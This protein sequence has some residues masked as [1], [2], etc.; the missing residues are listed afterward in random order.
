MKRF[1][2]KLAV[3]AMLVVLLAGCSFNGG[4]WLPAACERG[5]TETIPPCEPEGKA[6]FGFHA[7]Y[8]GVL[9]MG[10]WNGG[11]EYHDHPMKLAIHARMEDASGLVMDFPNIGTIACFEFTWEKQGKKPTDFPDEGDGFACVFDGGEGGQADHEDFL[12]IKLK[13]GSSEYVNAGFLGGGNIQ[14]HE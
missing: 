1:A 6:T 3:F 4:G 11:F 14:Y 13:N 7:E 9:P 10:K 5:A 8:T 2:W 12:F